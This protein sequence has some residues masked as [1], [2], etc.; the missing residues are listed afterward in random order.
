MHLFERDCSVQRRYQK[1]IEE[2]PAPGLPQDIRLAMR[3]AA[4]ALV[5]HQRYRGAG[6]VEFIYEPDRREFF[7]LERS[8][9]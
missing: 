2:A 6:T 5:H 4:L 8:P 7:F 3:E 1:V 9:R